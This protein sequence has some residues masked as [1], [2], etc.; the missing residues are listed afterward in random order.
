[1]QQ[2]NH[3]HHSDDEEEQ[4]FDSIIQGQLDSVK[5]IIEHHSRDYINTIRQGHVR[6]ALMLAAKHNH[7]DI[8][9]FLLS[10]SDS[11]PGGK[12]EMLDTRGTLEMRPLEYAVL[13]GSEGK[14]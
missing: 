1:M 6:S 2:H 13:Y 7:I 12:Q 9:T 14:L 8:V 5:H 4:F 3:H 10:L 11:L